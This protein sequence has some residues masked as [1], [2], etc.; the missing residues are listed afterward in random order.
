VT[1]EPTVDT[2]IVVDDDT[3]IA[4]LNAEVARLQAEIDRLRVDPVRVKADAYRQAWEALDG[5]QRAHWSPEWG[6]RYAS[7]FT[8]SE[9]AEVA[10]LRAARGES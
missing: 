8:R 6:E 4:L 1:G 7:A 2:G 9:A 3:A 10:L 5:V